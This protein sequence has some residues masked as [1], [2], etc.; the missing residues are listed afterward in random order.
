MRKDE[1]AYDTT[2]I[3]CLAVAWTVEM[4]EPLLEGKLFTIHTGHRDFIC[5]LNMTDA[6]IRLPSWVLR[7]L[8][9]Y[10]D[11]IQSAGVRKQDSESL[12]R[13]DTAGVDTKRIA[14]KFAS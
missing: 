12:P 2:E 4:L 3:E 6:K 7:L 1:P 10:S 9:F 8:V 14:G 11:V 5:S 13:L